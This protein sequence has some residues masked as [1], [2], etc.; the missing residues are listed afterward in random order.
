LGPISIP[1]DVDVISGCPL[2]RCEDVLL[3]ADGN[4]KHYYVMGGNL[5]NAVNA[6]YVRCFSDIPNLSDS[7]KVLG[8]GCFFVSPL[9]RL[10]WLRQFKRLVRNTYM[11]Q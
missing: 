1:A 8:Q 6:A 9:N 10:L 4:N 5:A 3:L 2:V 11:G 7:I